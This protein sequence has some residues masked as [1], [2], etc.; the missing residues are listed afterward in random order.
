M[1]LIVLVAIAMLADLASFSLIV[2]IVGIGA[3]SNGLMV[4]T[5]LELGILGVAVLK[6]ALTVVI[7]TLVLRVRRP[8]LRRVAAGLGIAVGLVGLIGNVAAFWR[9]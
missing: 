5:Y 2:P 3:E 7:L 4:R 1:S 8:D 6:V 9:A